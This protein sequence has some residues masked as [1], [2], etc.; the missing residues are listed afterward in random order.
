MKLMHNNR[1]LALCAALGILGAMAGCSDGA[2]PEPGSGGA[3]GGGENCTWDG[4]SGGV[5]IPD[6]SAYRGSYHL[7]GTIDGNPYEDLSMNNP[8]AVD[9]VTT[10]DISHALDVVLHGGGYL[11]LWWGGLTPSGEWIDVAGNLLLPLEKSTRTVKWGSQV[12]F[13]C[14]AFLYQYILIVDGGE[15]TG[16]SVN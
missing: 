15:L 6:C 13:K 14:G 16:C 5:S 7:V 1:K 12:K 8:T 10:N 2:T 4:T 9:P 11:H 3:D